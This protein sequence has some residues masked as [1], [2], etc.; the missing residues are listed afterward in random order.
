MSYFAAVFARTPQGWIGDETTLE[1]VT[2]V[3][4]LADLMREAAMEALGDP[5][6]LLA[7]AD[8]EWFAVARLD[9]EGEV[10]AFLSAARD[11]GVA[12]LFSQ[13][14]GEVAEGEAGG[15]AGLLADLGVSAERLGELAERALPADALLEIAEQAGFGDDFDNLR[16]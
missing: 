2:G 10:R 12:A 9:D 11:E 7:E 3:D 13:L 5:V 6:L 4:D 14:I 1:E 8:D 16:A 15:E